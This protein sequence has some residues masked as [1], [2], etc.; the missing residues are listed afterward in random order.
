MENTNLD[1]IID[2]YRDE[3]VETMKR[4]IAIPSIS[5]S[6]GGEGESKRAD[7]LQAL[8]ESFG[9]KTKRYDYKDG[10]ST[11]SNLVAK[12]GNA[13]STIWLIAHIDTVAPGD[14]KAW[15]HDPFDAIVKDGRIYG[16][17]TSD[18]G[19]DVIA[20]IYALKAIIDSKLSP[21]YN[22]G[23]ALVADEEVGSAWGMGRLVE[24]GIFNSSDM[25][26]VPDAGSAGGDEIEIAEKGA[27]W[28]KISTIGKQIHASTPDKGINAH[29]HAASLITKID[30]FLHEKY[31]AS[32][33]MF[34]PRVSTFEPTKHELNVDSVNIVPGSDVSYIDCRV[35][36]DYSLDEVLKDIKILAEEEEKTEDGLKI[37]IETV[38]RSDTAQPTSGDSDIIMM[39]TKS[40]GN[41]LG[42]KPKL[43]GIGGGTV[44]F[45]L[46]K[47]GFPVG[48]W[49][50]DDGTAHQID[51]YCTISNIT[52]DA[53]VFAGLFT[54]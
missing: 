22:F 30:R 13:K 27:L 40:V 11:R 26:V 7:F 45:F 35:L 19:Q 3:I 44:A 14:L 1:V 54:E 50:I 38:N 52:T 32:N 41:K 33:P 8:L 10:K 39:L 49:M 15:S 25:F 34:D 31:S 17:G 4:M 46:R 24:E 37:N 43:V 29:R 21:K 6:S 36:P 53:K 28:I 18:N 47:K 12:Y 20:S 16:R 5:P 48:V 51:E 2:G 42:I 9:L 23:L